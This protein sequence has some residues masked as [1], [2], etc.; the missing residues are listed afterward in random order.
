MFVL[1][2]HSEMSSCEKFRLKNR[3][4]SGFYSLLYARIRRKQACLLLPFIFIP[5]EYNCA[6]I[7]SALNAV[8]SLRL[9]CNPSLFLSLSLSL[10]IIESGI[11]YSI[12]SV[13]ST[14]D[15]V[16][17]ALFTFELFFS[18]SIEGNPDTLICGNCREFFN[19]L[20]DLLEHKRSYCKLR[21]T[22]KCQ[23]NVQS[24][25]IVRKN[26]AQLK[27]SKIMTTFS[28][29]LHVSRINIDQIAVRVVQRLFC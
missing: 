7:I 10:S 25:F 19:D 5:G 20:S 14:V 16:F 17:L 15:L 9:F 22:C 29:W 28:L 4:P 2:W 26:L 13:L 11:N 24:E 1:V 27:L 12:N 8:V 6:L 21:F 18:T 3:N 23:D